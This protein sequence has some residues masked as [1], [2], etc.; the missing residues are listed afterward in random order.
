MPRTVSTALGSQFHAPEQTP[1][2]LVYMGLADYPSGPLAFHDSDVELWLDL[3][4]LDTMS[5]PPQ[6]DVDIARFTRFVPYAD[7]VAPQLTQTF[8]A[9]LAD[10]TINLS[11]VNLLWTAITI[12]GTYRDHVMPDETVIPAALVDIYLGQLYQDPNQLATFTFT[13]VVPVYEGRIDSVSVTPTTATINIVPHLTPFTGLLPSV[14]YSPDSN[15][16]WGGF[17]HIPPAGL[18]VTWGY[19]EKTI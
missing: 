13:G 4:T 2:T 7:F 12:A 8:D 9:A 5:S 11:N 3:D 16:L 18:K 6:S 17:R 14:A 15:S 19:D 1:V 10:I